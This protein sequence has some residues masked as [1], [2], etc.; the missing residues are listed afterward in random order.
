MCGLLGIILKDKKLYNKSSFIKSLDCINHRGPDFQNYTEFEKNNYKIFFGHTRLSI[1][2][3]SSSGNQP[4]YS[5]TKRYLIIFNGEIYN[6]IEIRK[7]IESKVRI[8]W[9]SSSDT[10]TLVNF[11]E[12]FDINYVLRNLSGMFSFVVYDFKEE[13]LFLSR[14][15]SGEKPLYL[16]FNEEYIIISSDL[17][18]LKHLKFFKDEIDQI[19]VKNYL[20]LNYIPTPYTIYQNTFKVK[21]STLVN[22]DL[23][24]YNFKKFGKFEDI[25]NE[26]SIDVNKWWDLKKINKNKNINLEHDQVLEQIENLLEKSTNEQLISDVPIGIFLSGGID[27]SFILSQ[28]A[29]H[30]SNIDTFNIGFDFSEYDESQDSKKI[31]DIFKTNHHHH[32][33]NKNDALSL[34]DNINETFSEPFA[35]SSQIPTMLVSQIARKKVKVVLGG[36]G[37]D[38]IFGGYNRYLLAHKYWKIFKFFPKPYN[39]IFKIHKYIPN[40]V[41]FFLFDKIFKL[42][43][44]SNNKLSSFNKILQKL[45][46]IYSKESFYENLIVEWPNDDIF[47]NNITPHLFDYSQYASN[48]LDFEE[49]MMSIDYNT[50]LTDDILCK[51]DRSSM[52][53]SLEARS[54]FLNKKLIEYMYS[55]PLNFK[56]KDNITKWSSKKILEKYLPKKLIYKSKQGFGVPLAEWFRKDLKDYVFDNLSKENCQKHNLFNYSIINKTLENHYKNNIDSEHKIWSLIQF[57]SWYNKVFN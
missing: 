18:P 24:K 4:M 46:N 27:S 2:D 53:Y 13:K 57:N 41:L 29:K 44:F 49:W 10:E 45:D 23:K 19:A 31:S 12:N 39:K 34:I 54:P 51:V 32:I 33:C 15:I 42:G 52:F 55:L 8:E 21:T 38:E 5:N 1:L 35:D 56:I 17:K 40:N 43:N 6:H 28:V 11:I 7:I 25:G 30:K 50:Y 16:S 14:D 3:T 22:I 37:G 48:D 9:K 26:N 20:K 47:N 36:D